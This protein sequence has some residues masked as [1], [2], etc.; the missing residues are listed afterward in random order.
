MAEHVCNFSTREAETEA[1]GLGVQVIL[2][3]TASL[4]PAEVTGDPIQGRRGEPAPERPR[5]ALA[6]RHLPEILAP[7]KLRE[8]TFKFDA[9]LDYTAETLH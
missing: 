3:Y 6:Q 8:E 5:L 2:S 1:E 7:G 9:S 4:R